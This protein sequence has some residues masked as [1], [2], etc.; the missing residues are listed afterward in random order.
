MI[1]LLIWR[2]LKNRNAPAFTWKD[3]KQFFIAG[4]AGQI[5]SQVGMTLGTLKSTST[6]FSILNLSIPVITAVLASLMLRERVTRLQMICLCSSLVGVLL[7][8][9]IR[10]TSFGQKTFLF[11]NL[12]V[13]AGCV[14]SAFY[15][16]Y[17]KGLME[18][19]G[20]LELL[21]CTYIT[22]S[23]ASIVVLLWLEPT[24]FSKLYHLPARAWFFMSVNAL[25]V[26]GISMV[27]WFYVLKYLPVTV[28]S[29]SVYL[30]PVFGVVLSILL[31]GEKL[32]GY[33]M[34]GGIFV[35]LSTIII[36]KYDTRT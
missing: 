10:N 8:S 30:V 27:L 21:I 31:V 4:I 11:G 33:V 16:V 5:L 28:A 24:V 6:N 9:D 13:L 20:D 17:C 23:L 7:M 18:K 35:L 22:A 36:M 29:A 15:N 25:F 34:V 1:P 12:L 32:T 19:F 26:Y 2:R 14:G 3:W